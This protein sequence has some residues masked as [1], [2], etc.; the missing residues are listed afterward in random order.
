MRKLLLLFPLA[1]LLAACSNDAY[2]TGDSRYS[3]LRADFV[4]AVTD[5]N[6][7]L[8]SATTDEGVALAFSKPAVASWATVPDTTYRALLYYNAAPASGL[9]V[10]PLSVGRVYVLMPKAAADMSE[11]AATD[12][13]HFQSSWLSANGSYANLSL[14]LMTGVADSVDARQAIGLVCDSVVAQ[15][16]GHSTYYYTLSHSQGSVPQ[17]YKST[18]YVSIPTKKMTAGDHVRL[19]LNTYNGWIVRDFDL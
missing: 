10:E 7:R 15:S 2:D 19:S 16:D 12:P 1:G 5:A 11:P 18:I 13:V 17:Y 9:A 8:V 14:A 6:A 4:E 3:Y